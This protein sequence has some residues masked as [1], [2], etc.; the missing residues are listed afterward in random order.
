MLKKVCFLFLIGATLVFTSCMGK[1]QNHVPAFKVLVFSKTTAFRHGSIPAAID[2]IQ[3]L[4]KENNFQVDVTEDAPTF[5]RQ[6]L[7]NYRVVVFALTS[8]DVLNEDQQTAF[9]EF[10]RS[11]GGYVGIHSASDS[12]YDWLWYG[13]LVGAYFKDHPTGLQNSVLREESN[14]PSMQLVPKEGWKFTDEIYNFRTNPRGR[15]QVIATVDESTYQGGSM[16]DHPIVW[17]HEYEGGKA[18]YTGLGHTVEIYSDPIFQ[19]VIYGGIT[20]AA[21]QD[22]FICN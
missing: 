7:S 12:E 15:V 2:L 16:G 21:G 18:W 1:T 10:I 17:C 4:G 13:R 20:Y 11:R 14:H 5:N 9:E 3:K 22:A 8:G 19:Q 6:N